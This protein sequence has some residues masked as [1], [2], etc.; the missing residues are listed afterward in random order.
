MSDQQLFIPKKI[1]VGYQERTDTYSKKLAY[2]IYYDNKGVLRKETSWKSWC[3]LEDAYHDRNVY[4][5]QKKEFKKDDN[6][7]Y[8][9]ERTLTHKGMGSDDF[10]NVPL[11]GF[12]LNKKAGGYSTGW[13]HRQTYCRVFDPRGFEIEI[14][15]PNLLFILEMSNSFKG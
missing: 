10:D 2:V 15:I 4:D 1:K 6:G 7:K 14:S 8:I 12:V 11:S 13:N 3:H 5:S 9:V